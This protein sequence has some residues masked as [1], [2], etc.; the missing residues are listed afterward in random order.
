MDRIRIAPP[1]HSHA[2]RPLYDFRFHLRFEIF[3]MGLLRPPE[4]RDHFLG[5]SQAPEIS[6]IRTEVP[7]CVGSIRD[8]AES[9]FVHFFP[10]LGP[11]R[12]AWRAI[13]SIGP[14]WVAADHL[15]VCMM[16]QCGRSVKG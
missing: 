10:S 4:C 3:R 6:S 1:A 13:R 8:I 9:Y 2:V 16:P 14:L 11:P 12:S 7:L 5:L 15:S